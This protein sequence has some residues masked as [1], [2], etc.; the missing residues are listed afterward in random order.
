MP[1]RCVPGRPD[2]LVQHCARAAESWLELSVTPA[3]VQ[4][5]QALYCD[6]PCHIFVAVWIVSH[7]QPLL[8]LGRAWYA[9]T[10][11]K[12]QTVHCMHRRAL[13]HDLRICK[14]CPIGAFLLVRDSAGSTSA[15]QSVGHQHAVQ[16]A[17]GLA[18]IS[19]FHVILPIA[20]I[21]F[22]LRKMPSMW[23][24]ASVLLDGLATR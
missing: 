11:R 15:P 2:C 14:A 1:Q 9:V 13:K 8:R 24:V 23:S 18:P 5:F 3:S 20:M 12:R 19:R 4:H 17:R 22:C 16:R 6:A 7:V 10:L 21:E